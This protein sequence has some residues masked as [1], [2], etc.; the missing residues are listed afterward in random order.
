M[1]KKLIGYHCWPESKSHQCCEKDYW[2]GL[3]LIRILS[4]QSEFI[5]LF[6]VLSL[7]HIFML[8]FQGVLG[9]P[10]SDVGIIFRAALVVIDDTPL[11]K[12]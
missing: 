3:S 7:V 6:C 9:V 5:L 12:N 4:R 11:R 8:S 10:E 1:A 2:I